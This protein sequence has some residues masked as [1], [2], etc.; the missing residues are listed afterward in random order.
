MGPG[1]VW[2]RPEVGLLLALGV[3]AACVL[4]ELIAILRLNGG[5]FNY[6]IDDPYIH[7]ALAERIRGGHYGI[8]PGEPAAPSSTILWPFLIAPF[9]GSGIVEYLPFLIGIAAI[10]AT[11]VVYYKIVAKSLFAGPS[12]N[13]FLISVFVLLL[14]LA[15]NLVGL[16]FTGM[17][18]SIQVFLVA[19]VVLGLIREGSTGKATPWLLTAIVLAPSIRYESL[20][21]SLGA[22]VYLFVRGHRRAAILGSVATVLPLALFSVFLLHQ[23]LGP[24]PTSVLQKAPVF[25]ADQHAGILSGLRTALRDPTGALLLVAGVWAVSLL[26]FSSLPAPEKALAGCLALA[27]S[28]HA[29]FGGYGA[30]HRWELYIVSFVLLVLLYLERGPISA[31]IARSP[32]PLVAAVGALW[33]VAVGSRYLFG[34]V[35]IPVAANNIYEQQYQMHRYATEYEHKAVAVND[36]GY[37][38]FGNSNYVL[39]LIGLG[40]HVPVGQDSLSTWVDR[41]VAEHGIETA[42][43]YEKCFADVPRAWRRVGVL[44]L[45]RPKIT[46]AWES[47]SFFAT[48]EEAYPRVRQRVAAFQATLPPRV[49]F[50]FGE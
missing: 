36:L 11:T 49:R 13:P 38:S 30:Y 43:L 2:R 50:E 17:E 16:P 44:H 45:S 7:L 35:T 14:A 1:K 31:V 4:A 15:T 10:S 28:L 26:A 42:M 40:S 33:C 34:L 20:A 24:L 46:A 47:V 5:H 23:G 25:A 18:H 29:A 8:N 6:T 37:V 22:L 32:A 3:L 48:S 21:V 9:A 27:I 39:D 12:A 19:V 41:P